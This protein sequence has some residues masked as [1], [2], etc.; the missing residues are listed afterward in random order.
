MK[1]TASMEGFSRCLDL[2][3]TVTVVFS[4]IFSFLTAEANVIS[5]TAGSRVTLPCNTSDGSLTQVT[6]TMN[7]VLLLTFAPPRELHWTPRAKNMS[8]NMPLLKNQMYELVIDAAQ[9]FHTGN[10]SCATISSPG[11]VW[12]KHWEL[13]ITDKGD[14]WNIPVPIVATVVAAVSV[15][16]I[17]TLVIACGICKRRAKNNTQSSTAEMHQEQPADIYE[18]CLE[19]QRYQSQHSQFSSC[20]SRAH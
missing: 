10:Y 5:K 20:N 4:I 3:R 12:E 13:I 6:W 17:L 16:F 7:G 9:K 8:L 11:G 1:L 18:N 2:N 19:I 15:V 14:N